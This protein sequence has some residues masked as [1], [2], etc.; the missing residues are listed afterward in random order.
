MGGGK[1]VEKQWI[2]DARCV[3]FGRCEVGLC[4]VDCAGLNGGCVEGHHQCG[5]EGGIRD[6]AIGFGYI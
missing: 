4:S 6:G 3:L 1:G 2:V 5:F